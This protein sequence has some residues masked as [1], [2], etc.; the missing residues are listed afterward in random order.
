MSLERSPLDEAKKTM[1]PLKKYKCK[2]C[3]RLTHFFNKQLYIYIY[4]YNQFFIE[5]WV[6]RR[7]FYIDEKKLKKFGM[8][9]KLIS[10]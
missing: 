7:H 3:Q 2:K 10:A 9:E 6:N 4:I 1:K 8:T 5:K